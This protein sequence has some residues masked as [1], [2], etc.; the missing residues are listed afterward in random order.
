MKQKLIDPESILNSDLWQSLEEAKKIL[1]FAYNELAN[2]T[3]DEFSK[4][5]DT[6]IRNKIKD[7]LNIED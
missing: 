2:M 4:G 3:T 1:L 6:E 7:F 5:G